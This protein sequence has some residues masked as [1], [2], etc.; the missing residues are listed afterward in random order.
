MFVVE[1]LEA[2]RGGKAIARLPALTLGPGEGALLVGPSGSGKTTLLLA[3]AGLARAFA[4]RVEIDGVDTLSLK[5]AALDR[6]RGRQIGFIFQDIHLIPGLTA[7]QNLLLAPFAAGA[8]QDGKRA[9]GLLDAMGLAGKSR[10][11]A[12][13]LSRGE[14]QRAAIARA[15]LL[16]PKVILADEPTA[17]LDDTACET[18]TNLLLKAAEET[19]AALLIAT[20]DQRL[21]QRLPKQVSVEVLA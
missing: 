15:M 7:L 6:F 17:S 4:G 2:G 19:Q 14:A 9:E 21:R 13:T 16:R 20:H 18:V 5:G 8:E 12:E 10:R 1:A 3:S 11:P